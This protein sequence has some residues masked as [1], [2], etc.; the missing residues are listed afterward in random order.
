MPPGSNARP[1]G[2]RGSSSPQGAALEMPQSSVPP[3]SQRSGSWHYHTKEYLQW[4]AWALL[5]QFPA[6]KPPTVLC[7]GAPRLYPIG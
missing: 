3:A 5:S 2:P 4:G 7:L 1:I 6:P